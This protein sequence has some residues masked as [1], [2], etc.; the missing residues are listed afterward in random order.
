MIKLVIISK[1]AAAAPLELGE[2]WAT[3]GRADGNTLQVVEPSISGRHCEV[4]AQG[5]QLLVRD[6]L[7]TNGTFANG[8]KISEA[9][10]NV[11]ESLRLGDVELR[12]EISAPSG[13]TS[14]I[15]KML[16]TTSA[17]ATALTPVP[18]KNS[19]VEKNPTPKDSGGAS[20]KFQVLFVDDSL[21]FL[22]NFGG[23]CTELANKTWDVLTAT[24]AD[25]A[26]ATLKGSAVD[27]VVLDIGMPM[28]DGLQLLAI[29]ARRYPGLKIAVMTGKAT[30]TNRTDSLANGADL[31]LEK[32]LTSE[33]MK[34]VF[35]MLN[36][37]VSWSALE[38]FT[39]AVRNVGLQE[40]VQMECNGRHS[41]ILEIRNPELRGQIFIEA[42]VITHAAVG[43]LTGEQA[44]YK[45]MSM[46]GGQFH[47]LAF[48]APP[49]RTIEGRWEFLLMDAA[50]ATDE[51]TALVRK[52]SAPAPS[53]FVSV[54]G[55]DIIEVA[56]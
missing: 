38:G 33:G 1:N 7:S 9:T 46:R 51:E 55:A 22:E 47:V 54:H 13:G 45:L 44:F 53:A 41:S 29:I 37:L 24:S 28:L 42:G 34:S 30:A 43:E 32:P 39:G 4:R 21:A 11:G 2:G 35:N 20:K 27:L 10:L 49:Q 52:I 3:V 16:M 14:F 5:E 19:S 6:L 36:D 12:M 25:A 8:K 18:A 56:D 15:S 48:R 40:V 50:R 17:A 31:F 26:L 23:V